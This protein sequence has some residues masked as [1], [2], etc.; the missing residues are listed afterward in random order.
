[1]YT[2]DEKDRVIAL[3]DFPQSSVGAPVPIIVSDEFTTAV[4]FYLQDTP[5]DWDGTQVHIVSRESEGEPLA[6]VRFSLCYAYSFG[7]P[8]DEAFSGH[9]LADRG[10]SPYGAF[11]VEDSSWL[12][13]LERMNSVHHS[14]NP[15]R[16]WRRKHYICVRS[17]TKLDS[18]L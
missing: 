1:M 2:V 15:E 3:E 12:R 6:I 14:H 17:V 7:P 10:L 18:L 13:Q 16:F 9:P 11:E 8:N 5:E 4:A